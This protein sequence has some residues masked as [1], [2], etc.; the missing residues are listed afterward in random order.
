MNIRLKLALDLE[1]TFN[2]HTPISF[3]E[4]LYI[5]K[6]KL[7]N[8][9]L[10]KAKN[11]ITFEYGNNQVYNLLMPDLQRYE[12]TEELLLKRFLS[13]SKVE[14]K[15]EKSTITHF[16]EFFEKSILK[17]KGISDEYFFY[18]L[19]EIEWKFNNVQDKN[20]IDLN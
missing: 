13:L 3:D 9:K 11:I 1:K 17:Y 4:Y 16:W 12:E 6:S 19:K 7:K 5:E 2:L 10:H 14:S 18:Y 8:K 20:I 15:T